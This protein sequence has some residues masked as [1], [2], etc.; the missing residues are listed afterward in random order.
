MY[1]NL[2]KIINNLLFVWNNF[3]VSKYFNRF[4]DDYFWNLSEDIKR[5]YVFEDEYNDS[6]ITHEDKWIYLENETKKF[7]SMQK[8]LLNRLPDIWNKSELNIYF[9]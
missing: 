4:F 5:K 9:D 8:F 1:N 6:E 2:Q 3:F 7:L